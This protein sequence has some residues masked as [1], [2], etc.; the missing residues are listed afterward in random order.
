MYSAST[1]RWLWPPN[2]YLTIGIRARLLSWTCLDMIIGFLL[3]FDLIVNCKMIFHL[4]IETK[5]FCF[6][7]GIG[8]LSAPVLLP[9]LCRNFQYFCTCSSA[10]AVQKWLLERMQN[11]PRIRAVAAGDCGNGW[12]FTRVISGVADA[13]SAGLWNCS[14]ARENFSNARNWFWNLLFCN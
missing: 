9:K 8:I 3:W 10:K 2:N 12:K 4:M 5:L 11:L 7:S 1:I 14:A 6:K 13:I